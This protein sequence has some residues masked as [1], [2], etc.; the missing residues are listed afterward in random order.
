MGY[1]VRA[2]TKFRE[3]VERTMEQMTGQ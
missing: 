2:R 1:L 3:F